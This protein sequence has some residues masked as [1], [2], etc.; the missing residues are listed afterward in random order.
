MVGQKEPVYY[1]IAVAGPF[2]RGSSSF[3]WR[4]V[5]AL[6]ALGHTVFLFYPRLQPWLFDEQGDLNSGLL[7][8]FLHSQDVDFL[9]LA[10]GCLLQKGSEV[11]E[12]VLVGFLVSDGFMNTRD[13]KEIAATEAQFSFV[14]GRNLG[15]AIGYPNPIELEAVADCEY[16]ITPLANTVLLEPGLLCLQDATPERV[17]F[18]DALTERVT[19]P[20]R[21]LGDGWDEPYRYG[22]A[23][24]P[25]DNVIV[26]ASRSS[27]GCLRFNAGEQADTFARVLVATD[28]VP[29]VEVGE[30][31]TIKDI[32][33]RIDS[34]AVTWRPH[35][36]G[37]LQE[38][39]GQEQ[40]LEV[41][42]AQALSKVCT[43]VVPER[44]FGITEPRR[45][46]CVLA[47][48]GRGNF[49]DEYIF[50]TIER[51][52]RTVHPGASVV[53]VSENPQH[54]MMHR[55]TYA[56]S[57]DETAMLNYVLERSS[58]AL[59]LAGLLFDQG[60]RWTMGKA[61]VV[62]MPTHSDIPGIAS[63]VTL[64]R[65]NEATTLF[66]GIGAGP[67]NNRDSQLLV[68]LMGTMGSK[69]LGRDA[70]TTK[71]IRDC[72]VPESQVASYADI[73]FLGK[74]EDC[75]HEDLVLVD[76][77][78]EKNVPPGNKMLAISLRE[79]EN[80]PA[81]FAIRFAHALDELSKLNEHM[82]PVFCVLD[83]SDR[84]IVQDVIDA[85]DSAEHALVFD[86]GDSVEALSE[87]LARCYLGFSMRYHCSLVLMRNGVP[88]VGLAYLPKVTGLY[89]EMGATDAL[90]S[91]DASASLIVETINM[92]ASEHDERS[93]RVHERARQ[94]TK[95]ALDAE[96]CLLDCVDESYRKKTGAVAESA[97]FI[98]SI[99]GTVQDAIWA[100]ERI[101]QK[102]EKASAEHDRLKDELDASHKETE[103]LQ[104]ERQ[105][106]YDEL[107][108]AEAEQQKLRR[109]LI[110]SRAEVQAVRNSTSYRLGNVVA[111]PAA[112]LR[113]VLR[114]GK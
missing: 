62:G 92:L 78:Q 112:Q 8:N 71:L 17:A 6:E 64:A 48:V 65:L 39:D 98:R 106:L 82:V 114:H 73:A 10:Q 100:R 102:L 101:Q 40:S 84:V 69:F 108:K 33:S 32:A 77:W 18:L 80:L 34:L 70:I 11:P 23:P 15:N 95:R 35:A 25:F 51:R 44:S 38:D 53:A 19:M 63:F 50:Q 47:Y 9:L 56:I 72:G 14:C 88:S 105:H 7:S 83:P 58:V 3:E 13:A 87:L 85:M 110:E 66:Y 61:E 103:A 28:G 109:D 90:L 75:R 111:K 2:K 99:P 43:D 91:P 107:K 41:E 67:L 97:Y 74:R 59:V 4:V 96:Q 46:V 94:L 76:S 20:I 37:K 81:D 104:Q 1:R 26:Y 60:I 55:G 36:M 21:C 86:P 31:A 12:G 49:G 68:R 24:E 57:Q 89:Q 29:E 45:V 113:D 42:L 22:G 54:T 27:V 30:Q 93:A 79:Y 16:A 52:L 5:H